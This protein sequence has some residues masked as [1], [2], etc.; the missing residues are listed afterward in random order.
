MMKKEAAA[1][2]IA[3]LSKLIDEH[4]YN[5]YVEAAPS[6][7]D[8]EFDQLLQELITLEKDFPE[9][10]SPDS[11]TQRVGGQITKEFQTVTH[12]YPM[13]S[14]GN[15]YSEEELSDFDQR[16]RKIIP[17]EKIEYA[18]ELKF[19]GVAIGLTYSKG[20]LIRAVTRGDGLKGDDV[21]NNVKTIRSI[22]LKL[23]K[24]N[25][26]DEF[27]I[28]GEIFLS[29]AVFEK[30]NAER[31]EIGEVP[32]A[33]PRNSAAGTLK[34]Q[35][36]SEVAK[37]KLD[38]Y[39]YS[40]YGSDLNF[41]THHEALTA[42]ASWGFKVSEH[43]KLCT[44]LDSV[45]EYIHHWDKE[46]DKLTFDIDGVVI[47]VNSIRQQEELGF[48]A[49]SPRWAISYKFKAES[50]ATILNAVHYQ[51]GRTGAITPVANLEPVLL[52]GTTVK[53]ASLH[54]ADQIEKLDLHINDTVFV[55]K[56][57]EIIPKI[58]GVDK[59][60]R[61]K[62]SSP[63]EFP[64]KCP[65]CKTKLVRTEGEAQHYCPNEN[66]CPP[67]IKGKLEHFTDRKSMN[68]DGLGSETIDLLYKEGLVKTIADFYQLR[69]ENISGLPR[70]GD[71]SAENIIEGLQK[72][73]EVPFEKVLFSIG[74][75]FVGDTVAK[76]IARHFGSIDAIMNASLEEL[77]NAPEVGEKIAGSIRQ[78]FS[79]PVKLK[80]IDELKDAGLQFTLQEGSVPEK[81]SDRLK[82]TTI[83]VSGTFEKYTRDELK[84]LIEQHGGI[85]GSS[86]SKKTTYLLAGS[87]AGPSKLDKAK[88]LNVKLL[89]EV[90]F[91]NL[92]S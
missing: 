92:I 1:S 87:D 10:A 77:T 67:Q 7:S 47:K 73:K 27:E 29:H 49:K 64:D 57:G 50:T 11:P 25:Y 60:K 34:L 88:S 84:S 45:M 42:A 16:L 3:E 12:K 31:V 44:T 72:S 86:V 32:F 66:G 41:A 58:T 30:I 83:V 55:E 39:L 21:T 68:I 6:I 78:F 20:K 71:K 38:C 36:S 62:N 17:D 70:M 56:G 69:K 52:A 33:N 82:D 89:S 19:D 24:G 80:I 61:K 43:R 40:L 90:E 5:Y 76:K 46:R 63:V 75:R 2:R 81:L 48:T 14:L 26:P 35:D 22:P 9:L 85:N 51:V 53:R 91:I 18:A 79:D 23:S 74:I 65:E 4:N 28:R 37:R 54:N 15:T 59:S 13:L 8:F